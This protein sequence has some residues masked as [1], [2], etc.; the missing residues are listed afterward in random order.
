MN[1]F[2]LQCDDQDDFDPS[3]FL[4]EVLYS[5]LSIKSS[6]DRVYSRAVRPPLRISLLIV[7]FP[8][9]NKSNTAAAVAAE[10]EFIL[11]KLK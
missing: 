4:Y 7:L 1:L 3:C 9:R 6:D 8:D 5:V 11:S 2:L 10:A